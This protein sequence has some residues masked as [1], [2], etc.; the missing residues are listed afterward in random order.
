M[1]K[2]KGYRAGTSSVREDYRQGGLVSKKNKKNKRVKFVQGGGNVYGDIF[3]G[4]DIETYNRQKTKEALKGKAT[5]TKKDTTQMATEREDRVNRTGKDLEAAMQGNLTPKGTAESRKVAEGMSAEEYQA[6]FVNADNVGKVDE[7]ANAVAAPQMASMADEQVA[8]TTTVAQ[9][10]PT[11]VTNTLADTSLIGSSAQATA[12]S[13]TMSQEAGLTNEQIA[14]AANVTNA[15]IVTGATV[16]IKEGALQERVTGVVSPEAMATAA[17]AAGTTLAR[18]TRAK[19]QLRTTGL[20]EETI[21]A[22]GNNPQDLENKLFEFTEKERGL[23]EGLPE[24]ALVTTQLDN[25]LTG[26]ESGEIPTWAGP[27]VSSVEQM[28]AERGLEASTIGRDNLLNAIIQS[29][30]PLA[31]A[32]AQA[33]QSSITLDKQLISQEE[34][35]NAALRQQVSVQNAQNVFNMNMAQFNADQQQAVN[36]SKF[37]QTVSLTEAGNKQQAT[38][39]NAVLAASINQTEATLTERLTSQNAANFLKLDLTNLGNAQQVSVI[40]A[41]AEQQALLSN[42]AAQNAMGQFNAKNQI[43]VDEYMTN[44]ASQIELNNANRATQINQFNTAAENAANARNSQRE[45]DVS[46]FN[47]QMAASIEQYNASQLFAREQFNT[48]NAMVIE[49]SNVQ[50]RR[51]INKI[52]TAAQNATNA[53]NAQNSFAMTQATQAQLWQELRDEFDQ[54]FKSSDNTEQR[55]TQIAVAGLGNEHLNVDNKSQ[56]DR[57]LEFIVDIT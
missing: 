53:R 17:Q 19:K 52:D 29:A 43:Q 47:A 23:I 16:D 33:L 41:Q 32:N 14:T 4:Y 49:Q 26:I 6:S 27:A 38:I 30:I 40:N 44:L 24:E 20:A 42:Q 8:T 10:A 25:L 21:T 56:M 31:Q 50:W 11:Q 39:Q 9:Q 51:D 28:L 2:R 46:K 35:Q 1:K 36:N 57:V 55:K 34:Q 37:L 13:D 54:I 7:T 18:V 12:A 48:Q 15:P 3:G 45:G 22:L 5:A